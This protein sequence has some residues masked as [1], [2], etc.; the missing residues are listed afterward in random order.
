MTN[1]VAKQE[2]RDLDGFDSYEDAV[3]GEEGQSASGRIIQGTR[4][5]FT[6]EA[7]WVDDA[8]EELPASL[9]LVVVDIRRVVQKWKDQQ[10]IETIVL[11]PGEKYP[12]VKKLN[13]ESPKDEWVE[14]PDG[15][16]R[17][18]WQAQHIAYLLDP[19]TMGRY[20]WPTG[21]I[22][23]AICVRDLVDRVQWMRKFRGAHVYPVVRLADTFMNTR[24][25][26]RQRPLL[27]VK[28]WV[29]LGSDQGGVLPAS[30]APALTSPQGDQPPAKKE[31]AGGGAK[32]VEP[33]TAKEV[34][35]DEIRF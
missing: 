31:S 6:N 23:G 19:N 22:G 15:K 12:D 4:I 13:E 18:P 9:E 25:G 14:G 5:K 16:P 34:T 2:Q 27:E 21:T 3:E 24:F 20:T 17:G 11:G 1:E 26:G 10:P 32:T 7:C 30:D 33:P 29:A 28:R 35:G 8:D